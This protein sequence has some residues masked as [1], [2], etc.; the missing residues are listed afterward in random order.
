MPGCRRQKIVRRGEIGVYHCWSR[1][2]QSAFLCGQDA[3]TGRDFHY[4][5]EGIDKPLAC[6][7]TVF[8]IDIG[9]HS[10]SNSAL[11]TTLP[12]AQVGPQNFLL[13]MRV[14]ARISLKGPLL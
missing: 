14:W 5:R 2:V 11:F 12:A 7:V 8:A 6:Q 3:C 1:C 4:R 10:I 9:N 13:T